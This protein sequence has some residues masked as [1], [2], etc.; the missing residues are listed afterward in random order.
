MRRLSLPDSMEQHTTYAALSALLPKY[1]RSAGAVYQTYNDLLLA[2]QWSNLEVVD[3]PSSQRCG[4]RGQKK[5]ADGISCV[6]PCS[7]AEMLC[8]GW[9][10]G[11]M[12]ELGAAEVY[13]AIAAEDSSTVYYRVRAGVSKP[14]V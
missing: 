4:F 1:P 5:A 13:L 9:L 3:L 10:E 7:L 12:A 2:Q 14:P 11:V 8:V 6:V